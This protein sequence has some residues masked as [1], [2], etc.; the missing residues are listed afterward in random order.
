MIWP[1]VV[2]TPAGR[3]DNGHHWNDERSIYVEIPVH[4]FPVF[5]NSCT[6]YGIF[7]HIYVRFVWS[8]AEGIKVEFASG[9]STMAIDAAAVDLLQSW[10]FG[11]QG[12][13]LGYHK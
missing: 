4:F 2:G 1:S 10:Y 13:Q 6:W 12:R 5:C 3:G 8:C 9:S 11:V 7:N